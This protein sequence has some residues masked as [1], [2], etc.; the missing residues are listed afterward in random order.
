M[1]KDDRRVR[2]TF[3]PKGE[4]E[5]ESYIEAAN[6][7]YKVLEELYSSLVE[8]GENI[9]PETGK[10]YHACALAREL[11]DENLELFE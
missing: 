3:K 10:E 11:L 2:D 1:S 8:T 6:R 7:L 4:F 9:D 5:L